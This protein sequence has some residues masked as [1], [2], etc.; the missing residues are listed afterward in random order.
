MKLRGGDSNRIL[1]T[2]F[3]ISKSSV[4]RSIKSIRTS[5]MNGR[6]VK[7]NLGFGHITRETVI[8]Q[9]IRPLAQTLFGDEATQQ[10]ILVLDGTNIYIN[11]SGNFKFQRQ[12]FSLHK[13][14]PLVKPL[15]IVSTIGYFISVM[16]PYIAK[17]NEPPY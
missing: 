2:L 10:A 17:N 1:S 4:H 15:V 12:S 9:H 5:L 7:E 13:G 11:K 8:Q 6:F 3:N 16:G 14:R